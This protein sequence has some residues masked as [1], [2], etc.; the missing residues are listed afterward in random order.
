MPTPE[1]K[2]LPS[3]G[4]SEGSP[5][6]SSDATPAIA[7]PDAPQYSVLMNEAWDAANAE[8]PQA[9]GVEKFLNRVGALIALVP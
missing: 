6:A 2:R 1:L 3:K 4:S 5:H 8:L 7:D 9:S